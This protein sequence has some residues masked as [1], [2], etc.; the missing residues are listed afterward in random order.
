MSSHMKSPKR[1]TDYLQESV[2]TCQK[3]ITPKMIN[4]DRE[5]RSFCD[6]LGLAPKHMT[7]SLYLY[8]TH[9]FVGELYFFL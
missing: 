7:F 3:N 9:H 8:S 4:T 5:E 1:L 6:Y 2:F